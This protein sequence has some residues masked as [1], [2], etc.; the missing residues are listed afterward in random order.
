MPRFNLERRRREALAAYL[1]ARDRATY[2][3]AP[4]P[5]PAPAGPALEQSLQLFAR[6]KCVSCHQ[7]SNAA[8]L[9][10][11]DLAPDLALGGAR[12]RRAWIRRFVLEPQAVIPGTRMPTLFPLADEDDPQSRVTPE[13]ALLGGAIDRQIEAL[14]DLSLWWGSAAAARRAR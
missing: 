10:P 14:T 7:L 12:L 8:K 5:A 6:L 13:P 4:E 11:G 2:P 3:F 1:A 9:K